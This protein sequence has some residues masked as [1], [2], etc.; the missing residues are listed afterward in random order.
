MLL[1]YMVNRDF[2]KQFGRVASCELSHAN[3]RNWSEGSWWTVGNYH[4]SDS[5][6][7]SYLQRVEVITAEVWNEQASSLLCAIT[8]SL[9]H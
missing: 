6:C 9:C 5:V 4:D 3:Y 8:V 1:L 2:Y 7:R